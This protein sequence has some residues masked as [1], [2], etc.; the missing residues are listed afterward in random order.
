[1]IGLRKYLIFEDFII[2]SNESAVISFNISNNI[3]YMILKYDFGG[4]SIV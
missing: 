3:N 4:G 2:H 1:M